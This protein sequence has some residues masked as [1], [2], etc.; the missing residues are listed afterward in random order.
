MPKV[1]IPRLRER[2]ESLYREAGLN[3]RDAAVLSEIIIDA[4]AA[5]KPTHGL[6]RVAP[7]LKRLR[8]RAHRD[9]V[10]LI[11]EP[12]RALYDGRDGLGY[13]VAHAVAEKALAMLER[14]AVAIIG[15]RGATHTGQIGYFA[16]KVALAGH[17]SLWFA[18]CSPLAAPYGA[19]EPVL[20][21]NPVAAGLPHEPEPIVADLATTATTHGDCRVAMDAGGQIPEGTALDSSGKP[22]TDPEAA[23]KGGCLLPFGG[24]KGYALAVVVQLLATALTGATAVPGSLSDYGLSVIAMRRDILVDSAAYDSITS[25]LTGAIKAAKPAVAGQPPLLPGERSAANRTRSS[26]EGI[27]ITRR[28]Y[29]QIFGDQPD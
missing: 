7:Q 20:G 17:L 13:L 22:T 28:L 2:L 29:A 14:S 6:I 15:C 9:G 16:R 19:T 5:G 10:W 12:G 1:K 21:T 23:L 3:Q 8:D 4:E 24:H 27:E 25:E 18:N 11:D 26:H